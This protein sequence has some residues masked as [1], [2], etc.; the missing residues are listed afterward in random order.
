MRRAPRSAPPRATRGRSS[1]RT[2]ELGSKRVEA[3][4][5]R[6]DDE[7]ER[8]ARVVAGGAT[9][10]EGGAGGERAEQAPRPSA[11]R[12][13]GS[14]RARSPP[15]EGERNGGKADPRIQPAAGA[16]RAARSP[17]RPRAAPTRRRAP[18]ARPARAGA[19][20]PRPRP[21][22]P[23]RASPRA[24]RRPAPAPRSGARS[25]P[26]GAASFGRP[27]RLCAR[28]GSASGRRGGRG[29]LGAARTYSAQPPSYARTVPSSIASVRSRDRVQERTVVRDEEDGPR[30]RV[31]R[32]LERLA[33]LEV[34][35]VRRLV[36]D[37]EVRAR[38]H[39]EREREPSPLAARERR[40]RASRAPPSRRR[41]SG[42]GALR[43]RAGQPRRLLGQVTRT[44]RFGSSSIS[45]CEKYAGLDAVPEPRP[46][47]SGSRRPSI[48]SRSVVFPEPFG[49][50]SATCSPRSS[51][52]VDVVRG[53]PCSPADELEA[54]C[55]DDRSPAARRVQEARSR[56]S[57]PVASGAR[58]RRSPRRAPSP[59]AR[60]ASAWPAP[61]WP[62][63]SCSGTAP[64][65]GRAARCPPRSGRRS[66]ARGPRARPS[67]AATRA[68][69]PR[70][71]CPPGHEL[72]GRVGDRLEE[73]AVVRDEH[74]RGVE[75]R[76][77]RARA[78]R[79]SRRRGGSS[80]RRGAGGR[81]RRRARA[82]ARRA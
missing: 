70:S 75:G 28:S 47:A 71:R 51:A 53:A 39:D 21:P 64:R 58:P 15:R 68:R 60:S 17:P 67:R 56:A 80:A 6:D 69:G 33:A 52:N 40:R 43:L 62:W 30:E 11:R 20:R 29:P 19:R 25:R 54:G 18:A 14:S 79:G 44:V 35:V 82:P 16:R 3:D 22:S 1:C 37:E 10:E 24:R 57:S 66:S 46:A 23:P 61:A 31:E 77:L 45:C 65:T 81:G 59:A 34:E 78:T 13:A 7:V 36:E 48:V 42:R 8:R 55:L 76:E 2:G 74:D 41:G 38:G 50:T 49:P 63:P 4:E 9:S 32:R 72:E 26:A 27:R 73:P 5:A 12:R